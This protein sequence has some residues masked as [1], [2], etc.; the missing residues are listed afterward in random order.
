MLGSS[1]RKECLVLTFF[2]FFHTPTQYD[3]F[4]SCPIVLGYDKLL[5]TEFK[6][7]CIPA[8]SFTNMLPI[9]IPFLDQGKVSAPHTTSEEGAD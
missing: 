9:P 5:M 1:G 4:T 3:G 2:F 7:E 8:E 6:Y